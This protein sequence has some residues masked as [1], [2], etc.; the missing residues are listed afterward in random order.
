MSKKIVFITGVSSGIGAAA[1]QSLIDNGYYV[2]GTV[3][4][5]AD[6]SRLQSRFAEKAKIELF[7]ITDKHGL[8]ALV[9]SLTPLLDA[10]GLYGLINNAGLACPGPMQYVTDDDFE[11]VMDVNLMAARRITNAFLPWLGVNKAFTPGKIINISSVSGLVNT[12]FNGVYCVSKHALE[13]LNEVYR[14]ELLAFGIRVVAIQ[15]G[16]I[17]TSIWQKNLNKIQHFKNTEYSKMLEK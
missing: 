9:A 3:R 8:S 15:P 10:Y 7:D 11:A 17:K 12:P 4:S 2:I 16:P 14:R 1:L 13:S 6:Q 5:I